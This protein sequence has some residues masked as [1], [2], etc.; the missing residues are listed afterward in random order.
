MIRDEAPFASL[1]LLTA[2][3]D[4]N[5]TSGTVWD[6]KLLCQSQHQPLDGHPALHKGSNRDRASPPSWGPAWDPTSKRGAKGSPNTSRAGLKGTATLPSLPQPPRVFLEVSMFPKATRGGTEQ[7]GCMT[8]KPEEEQVLL[9]AAMKS[10][11]VSCFTRQCFALGPFLWTW[12]RVVNRLRKVCCKAAR[13]HLNHGSTKHQL[14]SD[15][16]IWLSLVSR[17]KDPA[18]LLP[19]C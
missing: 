15:A 11:D 1:T 12:I 3:Q 19:L 7:A 9:K 13:G 8:R 5:F 2:E 16:L 18:V 17:T 10:P 14:A 6:E 4:W